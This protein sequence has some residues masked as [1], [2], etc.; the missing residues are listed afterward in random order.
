MAARAGPED[1]ERRRRP[2]Q[3]VRLRPINHQPCVK[4][5][6]WHT[7]A[8]THAHGTC[9]IANAPQHPKAQLLMGKECGNG[10]TPPPPLGQMPVKWPA[11][12]GRHNGSCTCHQTLLMMQNCRYRQYTRRRSATAAFLAL[13][14][15]A[16]T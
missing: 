6:A 11:Q 15:E 9:S 8:H 5:K 16:Q 12:P 3:V 10:A 1:A 13:L 2:P 14:P 4:G 7:C